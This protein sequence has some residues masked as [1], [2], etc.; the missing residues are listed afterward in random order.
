MIDSANSALG[1]S[2]TLSPQELQLYEQD[3]LYKMKVDWFNFVNMEMKTLLSRLESCALTDNFCKLKARKVI[4]IITL[5]L[6][7]NFAN[8]DKTGVRDP[9]SFLDGPRIHSINHI[10]S[11][12]IEIERRECAIA[13]STSR[14]HR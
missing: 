5:D 7:R 10:K 11:L 14:A 9:K 8:K 12:V 4:N 13:A 3:Q 1:L 2:F 6:N